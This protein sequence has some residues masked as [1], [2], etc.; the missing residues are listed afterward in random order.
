MLIKSS[1]MAKNH[2]KK[3]Y[4]CTKK[5]DNECKKD[6]LYMYFKIIYVYNL[7]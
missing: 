4:W 2:L 3:Y 5:Y 7:V 1:S 6:T